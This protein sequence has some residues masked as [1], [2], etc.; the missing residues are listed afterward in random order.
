M[1]ERPGFRDTDGS[2][3]SRSKEAIGGE[4]P[5]LKQVHVSQNKST[6]GRSV[7]TFGRIVSTRLPQGSV[8]AKCTAKVLRMPSFSC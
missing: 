4:Q 5:W 3:A 2:A 8:S 1:D 6:L 7:E